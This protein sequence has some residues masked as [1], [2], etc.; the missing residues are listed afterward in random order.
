MKP[1]LC[2]AAV[3]VG[4]SEDLSQGFRTMD[5]HIYSSITSAKAKCW[6]DV[7]PAIANTKDVR[8]IV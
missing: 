3:G 2:P 1:Y 7:L 4:T 6:H 8:I 5:C